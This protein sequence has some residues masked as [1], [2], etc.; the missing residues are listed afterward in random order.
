[1]RDDDDGEDADETNDTAA[2][3]RGE[4]EEGQHTK[5]SSTHR[6]EDFE[7]RIAAMPISAAM[8]LRRRG[9]KGDGSNGGDGDQASS[10]ASSSAI[11]GW[12]KGVADSER[13]GVSEGQEKNAEEAEHE[14]EAEQEQRSERGDKDTAVA[15]E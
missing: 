11:S 1:M 10:H 8:P 7:S 9:K 5:D 2:K 6:A 14:Q 15:A 12:L 13:D 3:T 4:G